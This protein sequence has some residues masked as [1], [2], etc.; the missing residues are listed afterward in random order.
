M[1]SQCGGAM[2]TNA[3]FLKKLWVSIFFTSNRGKTTT[4]SNIINRYID[5]KNYL[6][7][8]M[9]INRNTF[10]SSYKKSSPFVVWVSRIKY[11]NCIIYLP[12][13]NVQQNLLSIWNYVKIFRELCHG[14]SFE[15]LYWGEGLV[16]PP[17]AMEG[18]SIQK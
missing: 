6:M 11:K 13:K 8:S 12:R 2:T 18:D 1:Q 16:P 9:K 4:G 5:L 7:I 10:L 3:H 15:F 17:C 14:F